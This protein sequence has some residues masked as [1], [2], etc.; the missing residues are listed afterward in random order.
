MTCMFKVIHYCLKMYLRTL[1]TR[2]KLALLTDIDMLLIV[3]K[4]IMGGI[5]HAIHKYAKTNYRYMKNHDRDKET[6]YFEYR[7][8]NNLY[9]WAISKK[10]HVNGFDW[11]EDISQFKED[12]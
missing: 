11:L 7:D 9:G 12:L 10:V 1:E 8:A 3:E 6:S 5:C 2:V 4:G